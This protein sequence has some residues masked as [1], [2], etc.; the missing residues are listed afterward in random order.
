MAKSNRKIIFT[1]ILVFVAVVLV[2]IFTL[3]QLQ[4]ERNEITIDNS[5][6]IPNSA[7][8]IKFQGNI[9]ETV[10]AENTVHIPEGFEGSIVFT[11]VSNSGEP[12]H[13]WMIAGYYESAMQQ[14]FTC[15][16]ADSPDSDELL[17]VL[18]K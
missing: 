14:A 7:L 2:G 15:S 18:C 6:T 13:Q 12:E 1:A 5:S 10:P 9:N 17:S 4:K 11:T 3:S 16:V 8:R